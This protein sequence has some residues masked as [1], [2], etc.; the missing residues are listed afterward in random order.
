MVVQLSDHLCERRRSSKHQ[1]TD[2]SE[3]LSIARPHLAEPPMVSFVRLSRLIYPNVA[4][5]RL[6]PPETAAKFLGEQAEDSGK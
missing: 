2:T 3:A 5:V 4:P 6:R 1:F